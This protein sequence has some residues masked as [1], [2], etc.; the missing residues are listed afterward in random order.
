ESKFKVNANVILGWNNLIDQDLKDL[1]GFMDNLSEQA[2]TTLQL[3]WLFA[4]PYTKIYDTYDGVE[5]TIR[6]G[7][8][9]CRFNVMVDEKQKELNLAAANIIKDTS[10]PKADS[11][12]FFSKTAVPVP[13]NNSFHGSV[14]N[15]D[16]LFQ[17]LY[18]VPQY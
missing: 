11:T 15:L 3:R 9:N 14:K 7:P 8:F 5:N 12:I 18:S 10:C 16:S 17:I 1:E 13:L 6:L 4:H 2:V